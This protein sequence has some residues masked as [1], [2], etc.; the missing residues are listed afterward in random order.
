MP[1]ASQSFQ[2][3]ARA[4]ALLRPEAGRVAGIV[5]AGMAVAGIQ[6]AEPVLFGHAVNA[7]LSGGDA[8]QLVLLWGAAS[9]VSFL[10][11][12]TISLLADRLMHR[13]RLAAMATFLE[14]VLALPASFHSRSQ[15][16]GLMRVMISGVD[17]LFSFWLPLFREQIGN[18]VALAV[19]LPVAFWMN[20]RLASLLG[21]LIVVY[22]LV[23]LAVVR[24][25]SGG[26]AQV[27]GHFTRVSGTVG[28]LF[29]N[30]PM[31]QSFLAVP[32]E[33]GSV[34]SALD[35]I[36]AAQYPVLNWWAV[37]AVLTRGA[38]SISI[39]SIFAYGAFL[40][41]RGQTSVGEI[42]S[43]V[44]FATLLIGRLDQLTGFLMGLFSRAP[45][46]VQFFAVLG[47]R[48]DVV[49]RADAQPLNV[50]EGR[51]RF[52]NV[53]FRYPRGSGAVRGLDFEARP[54]ETIAIVGPTGSGK[55]TALSLLQRA[56]DPECGRITI[57]GQDIRDVTLTSLRGSIGVV[58]QEAGLF[59]RT[60]R[61]N[62][63]IG[64]PEATMA[65]IEEAAR[66]SG[67]VDFIARKAEG[68]EAMVGERGLGLSGGER[69]RLAIA[70]ALLKD[71]PILILDEATSALD[72]ATE[73]RLQGALERLRKGRTTFVIAHRLSTIRSADRII[74][75]DGGHIAETGTFD[76]LVAQGG[77]F[78]GLAR[79]AGVSSLRKLPEPLAPTAFLEAAE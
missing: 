79:D 67:A 33:I 53:T 11:A 23:N 1:A 2:A 9:F 36:L 10:S 3:Y 20:W 57:D 71:A 78:A 75:L 69:Q 60:I 19:L 76:E 14:H 18:V 8:L 28:E 77:I 45:M 73:T 63:A 4:I 29:G 6:V 34:R 17:T 21:V 25:T 47:E 26:Q 54:G 46:L 68:F 41:S 66:L 35:R 42:V 48:T 64:R 72:T 51:V 22:T 12:M 50:T 65:E 52:E 74:V 16:G 27:E 40:A 70:R 32:R 55:S 43:F 49:E 44:G 5:L 15:S 30:V 62:I 37:M 58:F 31:L 56:Y 39:V 61:E 38:S 24:R 59:S 13:R 7:L